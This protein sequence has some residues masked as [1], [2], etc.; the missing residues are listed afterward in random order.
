MSGINQLEI[1]Q[2][3]PSIIFSTVCSIGDLS[4]EVVYLMGVF[5]VIRTHCAR[6]SPQSSFEIG[7]YLN[8]SFA[9]VQY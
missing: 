9:A 4:V 1:L 7:I 6:V 3:H 5:T 8:S 2:I